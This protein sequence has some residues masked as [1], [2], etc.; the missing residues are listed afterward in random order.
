MMPSAQTNTDTMRDLPNTQAADQEPVNSGELLSEILVGSKNRSPQIQLLEHRRGAILFIVNGSRRVPISKAQAKYVKELLRNRDESGITKLIDALGISDRQRVSDQPLI[1]PPLYALSLAIAQKC[2]MGCSYCYAGHGSFGGASKNMS[3]TIACRAVDLLL[4]DCNPK[5]RVQLTFLGG[6]PLMNRQVLQATTRYAVAKAKEKEADLQFSITTNGTL[7]TPED[8]DFFEEFGF[9]VTV[10]L[11]GIRQEHDRQRP[12]KNGAGSYD[13]IVERIQPLLR[14]QK[15]MQVSARITVSPDNLS[16]PDTL[17]HLIKMG[18]HSVGFSPL[19]NSINDQG[20]MD[21]ANLMTMLQQMISCGLSFELQT[22]QGKRY[23]FLN[24]INALK[25]IHKETHRPYPCGAGAG[26]M[27]ISADGELAACHR[28]V[29]EPMGALGNLATGINEER[30]N[31]WLQDRHVHF[32]EPCRSCW[33]R[34]LCGGGCH[35]E[36]LSKGRKACDFI[37]GWLYY[38]LQAQ[39]RMQTLK[40]DLFD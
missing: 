14:K 36:V 26:Y 17:D 9:A 28:F 40:P 15:R 29:N 1:S 37:R 5:A 39:E 35:H 22:L 10:S 8:A 23:P 6:E 34:Y 19:L 21:E 20:E 38:T 3:F 2:N 4:Q 31:Q 32:Q 33:A 11:D 27:G 16:L 7:L 24:M 25:E 18:F 12:L 30:Q 13:R